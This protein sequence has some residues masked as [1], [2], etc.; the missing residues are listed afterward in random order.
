M[1]SWNTLSHAFGTGATGLP[2]PRLQRKASQGL[3][4]GKHTIFFKGIYIYILSLHT[5]TE[6]ERN[7]PRPMN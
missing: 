1:I 2:C 5:H 3:E 7:A 4:Q 6:R